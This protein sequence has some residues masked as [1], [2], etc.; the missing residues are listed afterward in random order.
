MT[1]HSRSLRMKRILGAIAAASVAFASACTQPDNQEDADEEHPAFGYQVASELRT[2]N[3]GSLEGV[4]TAAQALS[5]SLYPGVYVPGPQGQMIPNTDLVR[6]QEIPGPVRR[7]NYTLSD[8]AVFSDGT[9]VTCSDYLLAFTAGTNPGIFGSHMPL[10]ED[11]AKL[12][13]AP[14]SKDFTL[15]FK[16]GR[17]AR[18][19]GLFEAGT[20]LPAHA[21]ANQLQIPLDELHQDLL[22]ENLTDLQPIAQVW[23]EG[24]DL[25][26]FNPELQ[27]SFGPYAV[28]R[29]GEQGEVVLR[30][31]EFYYGDAPQEPELVVW[32]GSADSAHLAETGGLVVGDL[33]DLT[34]DWYDPNAEINRL[35]VETMVGELTEALMFPEVGTWSQPAN[36][37][38]L[39][40]CVDPRRV[41]EASSSVAGIDVPVTPLHIVQHGDPLAKRLMGEAGPNLNVDISRASE[42]AGTEV[43]IGYAYPNER[44]AAMVESIRQSCE[45]AGIT[46]I[47]VTGDGKTLADLPR[48]EYGEWGQEI[49]T[50]GEVDVIL[51]AIDPMREYPATT[52]RSQEIGLLRAQEKTLWQELPSLPLA[53]QPATFAI[54]RNVSNVV[55]YTGLSGIGWNMNRWY[56][57]P[58]AEAPEES[59]EPK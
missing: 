56:L 15:I 12:T 54:D 34:P 50:E 33:R 38:A 43:R 21:V 35:T 59:T 32:P 26:N 55:P 1:R 58:G 27:V 7:V 53:A 37:Q 3:A 39:S 18:W 16:E 24:F 19:R 10:F 13:C 28:A 14:G 31:N 47:D 46:I 40:K 20:V 36:R 11:T 25:R 9:P 23:R 42:L 49:W 17:G 29:V 57:D 48:I 30:A 4:S 6:M 44:Y 8:S 52:N 51:H 41:A 22:S 5:G 45:P 2:T